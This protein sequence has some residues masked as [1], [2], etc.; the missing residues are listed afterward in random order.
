MKDIITWSKMQKFLRTYI[1]YAEIA[2]WKYVKGSQWLSD[3][4]HVYA[5]FIDPEGFE[6]TLCI[7]DS[8]REE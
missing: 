1:S 8:M 7:S 4:G 2:T 5:R 3:N 6:H